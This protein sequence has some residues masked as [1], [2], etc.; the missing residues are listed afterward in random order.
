MADPQNL[1]ALGGAL[2]VTQGAMSLGVGLLRDYISGGSKKN[3]NGFCKEHGNMQ[4]ALDDLVA[5]HKDERRVEVMAKALSL[6]LKKNG[7]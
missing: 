2:I 6:A 5:A 4:I 1:I 7:K 3:G